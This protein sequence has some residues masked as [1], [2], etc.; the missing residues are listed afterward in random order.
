MNLEPMKQ[1]TSS[2]NLITHSVFCCIRNYNWEDPN[3]KGCWI[4]SSL[5]SI[6]RKNTRDHT[7]YRNNLKIL[8]ERN[9]R[10]REI[11]NATYTAKEGILSATT[12]TKRHLFSSR[13]RGAG[14]FLYCTQLWHPSKVK[15]IWFWFFAT[16]LW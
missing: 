9:P 11:S 7:N 12:M 2:F 14:C 3:F 5:L 4:Q 15:Q 13:L 10:K 6:R 8:K 1:F 16:S